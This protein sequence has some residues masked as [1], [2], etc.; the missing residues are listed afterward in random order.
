MT[1]KTQHLHK[2]TRRSLPLKHIKDKGKI[3]PVCGFSY[4]LGV[5]TGNGK[6]YAHANELLCVVRKCITP[7]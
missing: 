6:I 1:V 3:C 4:A 5:A 2:Y 7:R